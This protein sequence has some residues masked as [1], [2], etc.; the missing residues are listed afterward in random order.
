M[1]TR[2]FRIPWPSD[3]KVFE[4]DR[5][6]IFDHKEAV[7]GRAG[8]SPSCDRHVVRADLAR[9]WA[10]ALARGRASKSKPAAFLVEGLLMYLEE[11]EALALLHG[12]RRDRGAGSWIAADVVNPEVLTSPYMARYMTALREAGSPWKF[13]SE[14]PS[15]S[16][17]STAGRHRGAARR[18]RGQLRPLAVSHGAPRRARPAA[19]LS[20]SPPRRACR[21]KTSARDARRMRG[22][23]TTRRR[24]AERAGLLLA[25]PAAPAMARRSAA[26]SLGRRVFAVDLDA[27]VSKYIGETE[28]NL[29]TVFADAERADAVLLFDEADALFGRAHGRQGRARPL[30][31]SRHERTLLARIEAYHVVALL[32]TERRTTI[33]PGQTAGCAAS[34]TTTALDGL[35]YD[36][37]ESKRCGDWVSCGGG[38]G[39]SRRRALGAGVRAVR[40]PLAIGAACC[41]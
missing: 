10:A 13:G 36:L 28:K 30:R 2:A 3:V 1:D 32:A 17:G 31:E 26:A 12:G 27:V 16:S 6:E 22:A 23:G 18:S 40:G 24:L 33:D 41:R 15:R 35:R 19:H 5:D 9:P 8:A 38:R 34:S 37:R 21:M 39:A 11:S 7:L 29:E 25:G 20:S 14:I 4:V